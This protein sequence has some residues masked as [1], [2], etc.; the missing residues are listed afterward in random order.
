MSQKR[1]VRAAA[2]QISPDLES[3]EGTLA[4]VV[5]AIDKA[6]ATGCS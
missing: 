6:R 1:I 3:G 4:K 2:V 5:E